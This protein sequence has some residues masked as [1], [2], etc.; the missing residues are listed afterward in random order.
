MLVAYKLWN[1]LVYSTP[2]WPAPFQRSKLGNCHNPSTFLVSERLR[3]M[4]AGLLGCY[5]AESYHHSQ[6]PRPCL[7]IMHSI[8]GRSV[9]LSLPEINPTRIAS[10]KIDPRVI[11]I[12]RKVVDLDPVAIDTWQD[13]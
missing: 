4:A 1:T 10:Q 9:A 13:E 2:R 8:N 7:T 6:T 11:R 5:A 3:R 12:I